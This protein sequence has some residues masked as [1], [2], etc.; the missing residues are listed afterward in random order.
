MLWI[1]GTKKSEARIIALT[2]NWRKRKLKS[3]VARD[4]GIPIANLPQ[5]KNAPMLNPNNSLDYP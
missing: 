2:P 3:E 4:F 5:R 1:F